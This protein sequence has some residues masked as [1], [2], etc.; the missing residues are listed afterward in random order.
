[1]H[2]PHRFLRLT[3]LLTVTINLVAAA[4]A[5]IGDP[6]PGLKPLEAQ[7]FTNGEVQFLRVWSGKEGLGPVFMDAACVRCHNVPV[8]GG[9]STRV[10]TMFGRLNQDGTFDP[11]DGTGTYPNEG[12]ILSQ[13]RSLQKI[14]PNCSQGG[15]KIPPD[16]NVV[17][18]RISPPTF[19]YGLIDAIRDTDLESREQF[20]RTHYQADGIRGIAPVVTTYYPAARNVIGR[21]GQKSQFANLVEITAYA[22]ANALGITNPMFPDEDLPQ[23]Q[24]IDPNCTLNTEVPNNNNQ[25][26]NGAGIFPLS[27]F[28]RFLAPATPLDCSSAGCVHGQQLFT[29][30]GC[31]KCH[32]PSYTTPPNA[33]IPLDMAGHSAPSP[34]LSNVPVMLYSDLLLHDL[35]Q[36]D[37]GGIPENTVVTGDARVTQ[38]RTAPLWGLQYRTH[39]MHDGVASLDEA[40]LKHS[41]GVTGEAI[42]VINNYK[43]LSP[44]DQQDL[45]DFLATR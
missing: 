3:I 15:E 1:M 39:F 23:G 18:R 33:R 29:T 45:W 28:M 13:P 38:W 25:G 35:G 36:A 31:D 43:A 30:V 14:L 32:M 21:F 16:A 4:T 10:W 40:I 34:A 44:E 19:G 9:S 42:S 27:H 17:E 7:H 2:Q 20:E 8:T 5:E 22:F 41:D 24:P 6:L 12:G 26:S 37:K 11:L